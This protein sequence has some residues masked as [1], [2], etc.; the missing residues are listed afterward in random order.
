M[1][2][3]SYNQDTRPIQDWSPNQ[4]FPHWELP[5]SRTG[6]GRKMHW[7]GIWSLALW[8]QGGPCCFLSLP[9]KSNEKAGPPAAPAQTQEAVT[10]SCKPDSL[11]SWGTPRCHLCFEPVSLSALQ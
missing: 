6:K 10:V 9:E 2:G 5:Q 11:P 8:L 4:I 7:R 1:T 3:I